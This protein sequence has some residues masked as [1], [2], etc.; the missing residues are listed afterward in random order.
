[1]D[2]FPHPRRHLL[3]CLAAAA[4]AG[5]ITVALLPHSAEAVPIDHQRSLPRVLDGV[6]F[7]G[8]GQDGTAGALPPPLAPIQ[9]DLS[10]AV[11]P[12]W[13]PAAQRSARLMAAT[14]ITP[15]GAALAN[16][17]VRRTPSVHT[18]CHSCTYQPHVH[19]HTARLCTMRIR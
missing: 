13:Y 10:G 8:V 15:Y 9:F 12:A 1:M 3:R 11:D 19:Q 14:P 7:S 17:Y 4:A 6:A 16:L 2:R 18:P 5:A